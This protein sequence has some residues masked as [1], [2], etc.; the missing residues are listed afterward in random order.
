MKGSNDVRFSQ[1]LDIKSDKFTLIEQSE[2][3]D[4]ALQVCTATKV[5]LMQYCGAYHATEIRIT[6]LFGHSALYHRADNVA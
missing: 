5:T 4:C 3:I 6:N 1:T 2:G